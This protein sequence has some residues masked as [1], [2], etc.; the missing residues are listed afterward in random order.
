[1]LV[2]FP[3]RQFQMCK[4]GDGETCI[5]VDEHAVSS[6]EKE[7]FTFTGE[8]QMSY[9]PPSWIADKVSGGILLL[10]DWTRA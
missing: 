9:C 2:G 1:M 7:G 3:I 10:D 6:Y 4:A 8:N 5:W